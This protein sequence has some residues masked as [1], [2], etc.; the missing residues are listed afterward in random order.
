MS[1]TRHWRPAGGWLVYA[2]VLISSLALGAGGALVYYEYSRPP[3]VRVIHEPT[4]N[5]ST[6]YVVPPPV[7]VRPVQVPTGQPRIPAAP[8]ITPTTHPPS[9]HK[10]P[11][12]TTETPSPSVSIPSSPPQPELGGG[13]S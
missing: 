13:S 12:P 7:T 10:E 11:P 5:A 1:W 9:T 6:R 8:Y 3:P 4:P 2:V